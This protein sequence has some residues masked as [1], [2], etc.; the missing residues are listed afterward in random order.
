MDQDAS[1]EWGGGGD[2]ERPADT[3]RSSRAHIFLEDRDAHDYYYHH[4]VGIDQD[5]N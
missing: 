1:G 2:E 5:Q 4:L 3:Q